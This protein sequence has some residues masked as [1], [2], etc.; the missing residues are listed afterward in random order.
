MKQLAIISQGENDIE[1]KLSDCVKGHEN[2]GLWIY[3]THREV[4]LFGLRIIR[5]I[6]LCP[7]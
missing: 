7:H 2:A 1:S 4:T 6:E 5:S 3:A